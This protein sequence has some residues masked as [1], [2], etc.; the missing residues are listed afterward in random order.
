MS[1]KTLYII[2]QGSV[3]V[4][5]VHTDWDGEM[6]VLAYA[7]DETDALHLA[8]LYDHGLLQPD[9]VTVNGKV[10][11]ALSFCDCWDCEKQRGI[12]RAKIKKEVN[13][14]KRSLAQLIGITLNS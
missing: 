3:E 1:N 9:N 7:I 10:I 6:S 13:M 8:D 12:E 4:A 5:S 14:K 11:S 2:N